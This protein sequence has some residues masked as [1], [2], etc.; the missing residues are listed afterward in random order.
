MVNYWSRRGTALAAAPSSER[1][2]QGGCMIGCSGPD[3]DA[4]SPFDGVPRV[5]RSNRPACELVK[6]V[7]PKS[8]LSRQVRERHPAGHQQQEKL[9]MPGRTAGL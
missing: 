3:L 1:A 6:G 9:G 2:V 8:G 7:D 4:E 5:R